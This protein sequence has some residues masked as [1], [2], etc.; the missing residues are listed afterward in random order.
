[1]I[2]KLQIQAIKIYSFVILQVNNYFYDWQYL[3]LWFLLCYLDMLFLN[4]D[5]TANNR[6]RDEKKMKKYNENKK[7]FSAFIHSET[8]DQVK[9]F[10]K[11]N[12]L[13]TTRLTPGSVLEM[14]LNLFFKELEKRPLE[15]IAVEYLT[16]GNAPGGVK[17]E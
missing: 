12:E 13:I 6:K 17:V 8:Y 11:E 4:L 16:N 1:M 5:F 15:D 3:K 2:K 14:G 9:T 10:V 7:R